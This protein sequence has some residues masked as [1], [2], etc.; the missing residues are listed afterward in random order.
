[1]KQF[2]CVLGLA[3]VLGGCGS[4]PTLQERAEQVHLPNL[5]D[6][7]TIDRIIQE[8]VGTGE[9]QSRGPLGAKLWYAPK[10]YSGWVK[11]MYSSGQVSDLMEIKE[12][13]RDGVAMKWYRDGQK[14]AQAGFKDGKL[15]GLS[16]TWHKNGQKESE[17]TYKDGKWQRDDG[18]FE[19]WYENGQ[20]SLEMNGKD[21]KRHG[22]SVTWHKNGQKMQETTYKDGKL[23]GKLVAWNEDGKVIRKATYKNGEEI[24]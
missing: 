15:H 7:A 22:L 20:K 9:L 2:L 24:R 1:M 12:G 3:V 16:V 14:Q 17:A 4:E 21:G 5:D 11:I 18:V 13:T 10:P 6:P 19:E 23:D 8:A